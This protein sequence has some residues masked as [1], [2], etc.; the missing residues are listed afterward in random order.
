VR[1]SLGSQELHFKQK[2]PKRKKFRAI[3]SLPLVAVIQMRQPLTGLS[4]RES[5]LAE[6]ESRYKLFRLRDGNLP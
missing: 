6:A 5:K 3:P 1:A 4:S 2:S